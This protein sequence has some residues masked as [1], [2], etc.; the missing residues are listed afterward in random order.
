ML[1]DVW[2][3]AC[4][5]AYQPS[6]QHRSRRQP[7]G[8]ICPGTG[9]TLSKF[10][11]ELIPTLPQLKGRGK[12]LC[13]S[14]TGSCGA[15]LDVAHAVWFVVRVGCARTVHG[16]GK[17]LLPCGAPAGF[18]NSPPGCAGPVALPR[19]CSLILGLKPCPWLC[20]ASWVTWRGV[21]R[22]KSMG[23]RKTPLPVPG[24]APDLS[25]SV[26]VETPVR[27]KQNSLSPPSGSSGKRK[28]KIQL[29]SS[30]RGDQ[31]AL[32][33]RCLAAL[34]SLLWR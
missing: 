15:A 9:R 29:V 16:G 4:K 27:K 19:H 10:Q 26:V 23:T 14:Q 21:E 32:V 25:P 5:G 22:D 24:V 28:R 2:D 7:W 3:P 8:K 1:A 17:G 12:A 33:R 6:D 18:W 31:L 13:P 34:L 30:R 11:A 20:P